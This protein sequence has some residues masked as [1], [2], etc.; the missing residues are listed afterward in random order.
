[1]KHLKSYLHGVFFVGPKLYNFVLKSS[2]LLNGTSCYYTKATILAYIL[3][4]NQ[5]TE[6]KN[7]NRII[8]VS[9]FLLCTIILVSG[10]DVRRVQ[11]CR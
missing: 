5:T 8:L 4:R 11:K 7:F 1:M 9:G 2:H 6:T 10:F 3:H